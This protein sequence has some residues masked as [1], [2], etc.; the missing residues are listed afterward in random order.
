MEVNGTIPYIVF[1]LGFELTESLDMKFFL[2][3]DLYVNELLFHLIKC[4]IK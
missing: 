3:L 1:E 4:N 2:L